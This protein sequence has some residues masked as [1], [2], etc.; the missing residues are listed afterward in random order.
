MPVTPLTSIFS[1][2]HPPTHAY[3]VE[4]EY[5]EPSYETRHGSRERRYLWRYVIHAP[6]ADD[7]KG[8]AI[9][10]F[11]HMAAISSVGWTREIVRVHVRAPDFA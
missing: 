2:A 7:A 8:R 11:R 6:S 10:E 4:I 3:T 5:R 1:D 9:R